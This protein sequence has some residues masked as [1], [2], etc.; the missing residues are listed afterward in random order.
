MLCFAV[1]ASVLGGCA[2]IVRDNTQIVSV[3]SDTKK[4][5]I[6]IANKAGH[7]IFEGQTPITTALKTSE[8]GYFDPEKYTITASKDGYSPQ[9]VVLDWHVSGWY[10]I[11]NLALGGVIGYLIVDPLTGK[12]YYIDDEANINMTSL[13]KK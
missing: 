1:V 9:T 12:M 11:G 5:N 3:T 6:K 2:T 4:V 8:G 13:P 7:I 10:Y